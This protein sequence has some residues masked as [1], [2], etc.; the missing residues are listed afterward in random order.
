MG[1]QSIPTNAYGQVVLENMLFEN[2]WAKS[3]LFKRIIAN[4]KKSLLNGDDMIGRVI[5]GNS[6]YDEGANSGGAVGYG[7]G[8]KVGEYPYKKKIQGMP[9][10]LDT[11][12]ILRLDPAN[13]P[14]DALTVSRW[15]DAVV[16]KKYESMERQFLGDGSGIVAYCK[17]SVAVAVNGLITLAANTPRIVF[18]KIL[19]TGTY[20]V[21]GTI[22]SGVVTPKTGDTSS[23]ILQGYITKPDPVAK[24]FYLALTYANAIAGTQS[25]NYDEA[26]TASGS[27]YAVWIATPSTTAAQTTAASNILAGL[28]LANAYATT[29]SDTTMP[30][31]DGILKLNEYHSS[32]TYGMYGFS[33]ANTDGFNPV[34][35]A[36]SSTT[37]LT[38]AILQAVIND[39][40]AD[41]LAQPLI[42]TS[43]IIWSDWCDDYRESS[44]VSAEEGGSRNFEP[45]FRVNATIVPVQHTGYWDNQGVVHGLD[46]STIHM[47]YTPSKYLKAVGAGVVPGLG[48]RHVDPLHPNSSYYASGNQI[49]W[50]GNLVSDGR[51]NR[52]FVIGSLQ[53]TLLSTAS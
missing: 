31:M 42:A 50:D 23:I 11:A 49:I 37:G 28:G 18:D 1:F 40:N 16:N 13:N 43:N 4:V 10:D 9:F 47:I 21:V 33:G 51:R 45:G 34:Y 14:K 19:T 5:T 32:A 25:A 53:T 3:P 35:A 6:F 52:N 36:G 29:D 15:F 44:Y 2:K 38:P 8:V 26:D 24:T 17:V 41:E 30:C 22:A 27:D 7:A 39:M 12:S 48:F 46:L 20:V